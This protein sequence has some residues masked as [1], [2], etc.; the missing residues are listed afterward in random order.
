MACSGGM[1]MITIWAIDDE[2]S[3]LKK[4]ASV[5]E[6]FMDKKKIEY[7]F[8]AFTDP[9]LLLDEMQEDAADLVFMDIEIG[10]ISGL[11]LSKQ[12]KKI[13]RNLQVALL[14]SFPAYSIDG[15]SSGASRFLVKPLD[16]VQ[17]E[18]AFDPE[19]LRQLDQTTSFFDPRI[20]EVP[21]SAA[22]ILY[23]ESLGRKTVAHFESGKEIESRLTL[24]EWAALLE[25]K[26]SDFVQCYK[27]ILVNAEHILDYDPDMKDLIL[28]DHSRIPCSR[29]FRKD[30]EAA[31]RKV[32]C[33]SL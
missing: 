23:V 14:S 18:K 3:D 27:S 2:P 13:N 5:L 7:E 22:K 6:A 12:L 33:D 17:L 19:F 15:Y 8:K 4:L 26:K 10:N 1:I 28:S 30:V 25:D 21:I 16:E 32:L 31:R 11:E 24:R 20:A 29:H 9:A